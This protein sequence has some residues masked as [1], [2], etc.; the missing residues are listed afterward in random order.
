MNVSPMKNYI[1]GEFVDG[2][3]PFQDINPADGTVWA[4]AFEA[5]QTMV[6]DAV[7]SARQA[8]DTHWLH[9]SQSERCAYLYAIA[10]KIEER[11]EDF[12]I[13]EIKDTGKTYAQARTIDIARSIANFRFFADLAKTA[14]QESFHT[15]TPDGAGALHYSIHR[16]HGVVAVVAPWNLPLLLLTWK[17]APALAMGNTIV[18]KPS[19]FTPATATLLADVMGQVG[20][21]H[22]VFNLVHGFGG[23][24][25]GQYLVANPHIDAVTFTGQTA[26]GARIMRDTAP[27]IKAL[28]F[29]L[30]GKNPAIVFDD[31]DFDNAVDGVMRSS[32]TNCGQVCLC[33]ERV[34]VARP[35][36]DKFVEALQNKVNQFVI[37]SPQDQDTTF[38][39]LVSH[40][41]RDKVLSYYTLAKTEGANI[42]TGGGTPEFSDYRDN[43]AYIEPTILTGL[44]EDSRT[45]KEEIFGPVCH[46][47]P[48]D[49]EEHAIYM[50]NNTDYGLASSV[51]TNTV[52][53][54]HRVAGTMRTG[55]TWVNTWNL[56]DLRTPFGGMG[57]SGMGRE[58]GLH[59]LNFYGE[60]SNICIKL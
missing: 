24:S 7:A 45:V 36:F 14:G 60:Q 34:Y 16:P 50:A 12:V 10:D 1:N 55:M 11:F 2:G 51:W 13:A 21:P 19:E 18:A 37:G 40:T 32:F 8:F 52:K 38:G 4:T 9:T 27:G 6:N 20:L 42:I 29:E 59:S 17:V 46:I 58:G 22:G 25:A 3:R 47:A 28:S 30:G 15:D 53:R 56:R 44:A 41:H 57:L 54:A 35:I 33:T 43:G 48:F 49:D 39:P 26:T 5:D 23:N 31:A